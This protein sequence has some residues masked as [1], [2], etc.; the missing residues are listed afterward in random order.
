MTTERSSRSG[1]ATH[2]ALGRIPIAPER[3]RGSG[4]FGECLDLGAAQRPGFDHVSPARNEAGDQD[5]ERGEYAPSHPGPHDQ[6]QSEVG[7]EDAAVSET[8][9]DERRMPPAG[10]PLSGDADHP[11]DAKDH[12]ESRL[13]E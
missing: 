3:Q 4:D 13:P 11:S 5:G 8:D 6:H 9:H 1:Y 7:G 12:E 10:Q 2:A